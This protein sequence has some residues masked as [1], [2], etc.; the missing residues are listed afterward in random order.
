MP[1]KLFDRS[2]EYDSMLNQGLRYSGEDKFYFIRGRVDDLVRQFPANYQP[3]RILDWGCGI[4]D[5]TR[6]LREVFPEACITGADLSEQAIVYARD[7]HGGERVRFVLLDELEDNYLYDLCYVNGVFHHIAP[8]KR[9]TAVDKIHAALKPGGHFAFFENNP[10][11]PGTLF[12]MKS[13]PFD[14]DAQPVSF[15]EAKRLLK[16]SGFSGGRSRFLFYFPKTMSFLRFL[17]PLLAKFPF[18]AQY[19]ILAQK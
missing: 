13:I 11:N 2:N 6:Y 8:G 16:K 3:E 18:G 4:G 10:W 12:I 5:A 1:E 9:G 14:G 17:E 7:K 19:Y 15:L